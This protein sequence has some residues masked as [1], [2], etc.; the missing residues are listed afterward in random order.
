MN[1][2]D[3][4]S[5]S[6]LTLPW[7]ETAFIKVELGHFMFLSHVGVLCLDWDSPVFHVWPG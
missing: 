3:P 4:L 1:V 6:A 2:N 7:A 5:L